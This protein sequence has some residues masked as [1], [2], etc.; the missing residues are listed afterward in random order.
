ML[1]N[2][3]DK[4]PRGKNVTVWF[5]EDDLERMEKARLKKSMIEG[6]SIPKNSFIVAAT[7]KEVEMI[8]KKKVKL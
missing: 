5:P 2:D 7:M 3:K 1:K 6:K 4:N 8:E